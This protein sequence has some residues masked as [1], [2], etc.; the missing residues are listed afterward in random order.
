MIEA[1]LALH[2]AA[3]PIAMASFA[4]FLRIG[5]LMLV[6]PGLGDRLIP[7]RIRLVTAFALTAAVAPAVELQAEIGPGLIVAETVTGLALGAVLRFVAQALS[8]AGVMAAQL[9]SL[10]Q[11]FGT[12]E[13]SSAIGNVLNLAGLCLIMASGL[14]LMVVEMMIR[15]Y[16]ILPLGGHLDGSDAARW[17]A[18]RVAQAFALAIAMAAPFALAAL[19]YNAAM[20]VIN[21]AMPQ[22]MVALV[23]APAITG[24]SGV[25]LLLSAP[26]LL[27][28]WK[29]AMIATLADPV[30]G[31][32]P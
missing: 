3:R 15:S 20:G 26:L 29:A 24:A 25:L 2:D 28:V 12:V 8:M 27:A 21:R 17:G 10:A 16:D 6:L 11:L 1:L 19:I 18:A 22:L 7:A 23:G 4:V 30:T 32:V 13:P 5:A 31:G 14:P 9:T